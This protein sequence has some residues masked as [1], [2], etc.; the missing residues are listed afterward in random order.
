MH[1]RCICAASAL[2]LR[3]ICAA[4]ALHLHCTALHCICTAS[5]LHLHCTCTASCRVPGVLHRPSARCHLS[6]IALAPSL[7][8]QAGKEGGWQGGREACRRE[9]Y[10]RR[11]CRRRRRRR[12]AQRATAAGAAAAGAACAGAAPQWT[13]WRPAGRPRHVRRHPSYP[14]TPSPATP[15]HLLH[16]LICY[17]PPYSLPPL[18][19]LRPLNRCV[20]AVAAQPA[21]NFAVPVPSASLL[22]MVQACA[23]RVRGVCTAYY[24]HTLH[25][26]ASTLA[27]CWPSSR[28]PSSRRRAAPPSGQWSA[29]APTRLMPPL[30]AKQRSR[31]A[32]RASALPPPALLPHSPHRTACVL[33]P[34]GGRPPRRRP[35]PRPRRWQKS[36]RRALRGGRPRRRRRRVSWQC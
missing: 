26:P 27:T 23:S 28:S 8:T 13:G 24:T 17:T 7:A 11:R 32:S 31:R 22:K 29:S 10:H 25:L 1:L 14:Y 18:I 36:R 9:A 4:S 21:C 35:R 15:P 34:G 6:H 20:E 5:A 2:H 30:R 33:R 16:P 19:P 12:H 3:C